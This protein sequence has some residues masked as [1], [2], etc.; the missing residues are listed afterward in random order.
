[1]EMISIPNLSFNFSLISSHT[2]LEA[3]GWIGSL[4][5]AICALPQA[6]HSMKNKHSD[7]LTWSFILMWTFGEIFTLI[8]A[9]SKNDLLPLIANYTLNL[10]F[11]TPIIWYKLYRNSK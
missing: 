7:G 8:Y 1:M 10:V 4:L 2:L 5:F 6:I 11:L 3:M 9:A